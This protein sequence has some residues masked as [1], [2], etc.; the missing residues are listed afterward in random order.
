MRTRR[1]RLCAGAVTIAMMMFLFGC[2]G[3]HQARSVTASG[4][5][6]DYSNLHEGASGQAMFVYV[7]PKTDF[8][9]YNAI[10]L[11]PIRL[12]PGA[13][14]SSLGKLSPEDQQNLLNYLDATIRQTLSGSYVFVNEPIP[15]AMRFRIALTEAKGARVAVDTVSSIVPNALAL[16]ML[17]RVAFGKGSGVGSVGA[18]FE[19]LDAQT[20]ERLVASVDRRI[21]NKFTLK[22]DK[23]SKW[24]AA[25]S[26]FDYW[27]ERLGVRLAEL[28]TISPR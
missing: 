25:K 26:A 27:A 14:D 19:A 18:E 22:F 9:K 7:N 5:L 2:A 20:G 13:K 8:G 10:V 6:G 4:F 3:T 15:G 21:G 24:R 17:S 12:Y 28:K 23:F 1:T 16:S 11:D